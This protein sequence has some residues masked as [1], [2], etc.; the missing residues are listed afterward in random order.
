MKKIALILVIV[1]LFSLVLTSC[2]GEFDMEK[3]IEELKALGFIEIEVAYNISG[4]TTEAEKEII[5]SSIESVKAERPN[6]GTIV[7]SPTSQMFKNARAVRCF[8]Q[9]NN[10][11]QLDEMVFFVTFYSEEEAADFAESHM[12]GMSTAQSGYVV[13][14]TNLEVA[15][16]AI[17]LKFD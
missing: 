11:Y 10:N 7:A 3:S 15:K 9:N 5:E 12:L 2:Q 13:V 4:E 6:S 1:T 17:N 16:K 8:V 14:V